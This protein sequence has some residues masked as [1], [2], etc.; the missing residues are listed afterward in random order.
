MKDT[1]KVTPPGDREIVPPEQAV[2]TEVFR[3]DCVPAMGEPLATLVLVEE[4]EETTLTLIV[5]SPSKEARDGALVGGMD[6]SLAAGYERL[7]EI[8]AGAA[9]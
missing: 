9:A 7:D 5:L 4:G 1:L 8:P 2:R 6:R 3:S